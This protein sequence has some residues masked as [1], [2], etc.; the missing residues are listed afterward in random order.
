VPPSQFLGCPP[1]DLRD[2]NL[3]SLRCK[4]NKKVMNKKIVFELNPDEFTALVADKVCER[5]KKDIGELNSAKTS[6]AT[7]YYT[8]KEALAILKVSRSTIDRM[9]RQ[10][11]LPAKKVGKRT[12]YTE[13]AL[14]NA[15]QDLNTI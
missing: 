3:I 10:G 12:L 8:V 6:K 2:N 1:E 7:I 4:K 11:N 9:T 15:I 14:R 5:L 13:E